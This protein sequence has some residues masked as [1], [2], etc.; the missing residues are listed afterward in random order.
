VD[1]TTWRLDLRRGVKFQ[2]GSDFTADDV[3][4]SLKRVPKVPNSPSSA[5][6]YIKS[7]VSMTAPD[8][9]TIIFKTAA[10]DP[11]LP[12]GLTQIL[13]MSH[14]AGNG[15]APEGK[16]TAEL[17]AGN[18][19][20]GTG[21][22]RFVGFVPNDHLTVAAFP[23]YWGGKQPWDRV[24]MRFISEEGA[25][26][27]AVMAGDI[28]VTSLPGDDLD[29]IRKNPRLAITV[30]DTGQFTYLALDEHEKTPGITGTD[31][32]NP[33][34]D[35]RVRKAL[36]LAI[37]RQGIADRIMYGLA[38]PSAELGPPSVFGTNPDAKPDPYDPQAAKALL[39]EAGYPNGFS[40]ALGTPNGLYALDLKTAQA[41]AAMWEHIGVH[42][43]IDDAPASV[44][45]ARRNKLEFS[46]YMTNMNVYDGQLSY[47]LRILS[48]TRDL[49]KGNGQINVSGYSNPELDRLLSQAAVTV[50]DGARRALVQKASRIVMDQHQVLPIVLH[51][52]A[53]VSRKNLSIDP[54]LDMYLTAMQ[55]RPTQ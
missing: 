10:P 53:Y 13:I 28:D 45:Y 17:N 11:S 34:R 15:P 14:I 21:P 46:A 44:F 5:E 23:E 27:A 50:D 42:T 52:A 36:S 54:R 47:S 26:T 20:V 55:V 33:L 32:V 2:D 18:G 12:E 51:R 22:Y 7:I 19:L 4:F 37:N 6:I 35:P 24:T 40:I 8:P 41:V 9:Y 29:A 48:M 3:I 39:T 38:A 16:T 43:R 49:P 1:D 31:G 25:R 30:G